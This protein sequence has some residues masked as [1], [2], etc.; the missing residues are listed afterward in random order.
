M[1]AEK[2]EEAET[3]YHPNAEQLAL[4]GTIDESLTALLPLSRLYRISAISA[5]TGDSRF[6]P[7]W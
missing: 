2:A 1:E 3:R 6:M 4:A 5:A 7:T